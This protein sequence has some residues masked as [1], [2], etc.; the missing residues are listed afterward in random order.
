MIR[1]PSVRRII[2]IISGNEVDGDA[3]VGTLLRKILVYFSVRS[4]L[5]SAVMRGSLQLQCRLRMLL[6]SD[7]SMVNEAFRR[8]RPTVSSPVVGTVDYCR[9]G[10]APRQRLVSGEPLT[11][12]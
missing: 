10:F 3:S 6:S 2:P 12:R 4:A 7:P 8:T 11:H 1:A 9:C 5:D